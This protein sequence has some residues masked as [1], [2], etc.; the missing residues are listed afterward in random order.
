MRYIQLTSEDNIS[1]EQFKV[2]NPDLISPEYNVTACGTVYG[3]LIVEEAMNDPRYS[4]LKD[5]LESIGWL[6]NLTIID[7]EPST[8]YPEE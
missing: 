2:D 3:L 6:D 4:N 5:A 1:F 7:V 8:L